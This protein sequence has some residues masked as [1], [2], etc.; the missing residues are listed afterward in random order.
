MDGTEMKYQMSESRMAFRA[1]TVR[2]AATLFVV[3]LLT[4]SLSESAL[5][6]ARASTPQVSRQATTW[7]A[8]AIRVVVAESF[9]GSIVRQEAGSRAVVTSIITNPNADPHAYEPTTGDAR[10]FAQS[11]YV[12]INGAGY[13]PWASKLLSANPVKGRRVLVVGDL[14][15]K[16][17]GDNPHMWYGPSYVTRVAAR[18]TSDL[19]AVE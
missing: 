17:E 5:V 11:K 19:S 16:K 1:R 12:V 7:H 6:P 15:G 2:R 18:V 3:V 10:L 13:D 9:W 14:L 4:A 8:G